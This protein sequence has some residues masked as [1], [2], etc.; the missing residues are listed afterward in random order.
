MSKNKKYFLYVLSGVLFC[1]MLFLFYNEIVVDE[2]YTIK[3][4]QEHD[5]TMSLRL[6]SNRMIAPTF[7]EVWLNTEGAELSH[8]H[9]MAAVPEDLTSGTR[10]RVDFKPMTLFSYPPRTGAYTIELVDG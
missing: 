2:Y 5:D 7:R 10:I 8:A 3:E 4:I 9:G 1:F 6:T